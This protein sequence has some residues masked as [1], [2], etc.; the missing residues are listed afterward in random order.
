VIVGLLI[1]ATAQVGL[2]IEQTSGV[3]W[4]EAQALVER[5]A[6]KIGDRTG[7]RP[8][9]DDPLWSAC[10]RE[11]RCLAEIRSRLAVS[12][13]VLIRVLGAPATVRLVAE[14]H[15]PAGG[16]PQAATIDLPRGED[17]ARALT[18]FAATLFP[19]VAAPAPPPPPLAAPGPPEARPR[20][21]SWLLIAGGATAGAVATGLLVSS[22][23]AGASLQDPDRIQF[24]VGALQARQEG[25][26]IA[27][28][29][30]GAIG[31]SAIAV[32]ALLLID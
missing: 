8:P 16:P 30:V 29:V 13:V 4:T 6:E 17:P 26:G 3:P 24:D 15:G 20:W 31:L 10:Q 2:Q 32:G 19:Q 5:L 22:M 27:G 9:I 25:H 21:G 1:A 14:R 11:D 28:A 7:A 23:G 18:A 12:T